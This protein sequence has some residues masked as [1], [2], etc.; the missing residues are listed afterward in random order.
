[1]LNFWQT[2]RQKESTGFPTIR[3]NFLSE[4]NE[5][6]SKMKIKMCKNICFET[7]N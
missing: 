3:M 1:M 5:N 4:N 2:K 6:I 7:K